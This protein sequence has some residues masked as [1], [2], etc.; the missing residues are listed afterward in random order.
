MTITLTPQNFEE[1]MKFLHTQVV[2]ANDSS[3]VLTID[4][5]QVQKNKSFQER[6]DDPENTSY[7]PMSASDFEKEMTSWMHSL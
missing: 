4:Y 6:M 2:E 1:Q 7:G 3:L 5:S